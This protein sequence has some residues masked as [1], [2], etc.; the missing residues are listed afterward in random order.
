MGLFG[1]GR[2]PSKKIIRILL[3]I[4]SVASMASIGVE[5]AHAQPI[6]QLISEVVTLYRQS[7]AVRSVF[8]ESRAGQTLGR[9]FSGAPVA[10]EQDL[11]ALLNRLERSE[12]TV[13]RERLAMVDQEMAA[14]SR[15][16][17]SGWN[18]AEWSDAIEECTKRF[19]TFSIE[20]GSGQIVLG[21]LR[22]KRLRF[23]AVKSMEQELYDA[24]T[25]A[26][27]RFLERAGQESRWAATS[28][29]FL[30]LD[31]AARE[32]GFP[33][34]PRKAPTVDDILAIQRA[35]LREWKERLSIARGEYN[36]ARFI[37]RWTRRND[38]LVEI[39]NFLDATKGL[40]DAAVFGASRGAVG[41][42]RT[43]LLRILGLTLVKP[44][45]LLTPAEI[46][47][48][49][50]SPAAFRAY[51]AV[52]FAQ[53]L[54][55]NL[56]DVSGGLI[57]SLSHAWSRKPLIWNLRGAGAEGGP[58][59]TRMLAKFY[60]LTQS[61]V[62]PTIAFFL[63]I[64]GLRRGMG[65]L[66]NGVDAVMQ[67]PGLRSVLPA[68]EGGVNNPTYQIFETARRHF[69]KTGELY[70]PTA[71]QWEV[72]RKYQAVSGFEELQAFLAGHP[73][74]SQ[75]REYLHYAAGAAV[76]AGTIAAVNHALN[77]AQDGLISLEEYLNNPE[78]YGPGPGE[79]QLVVDLVPFPHSAVRVAFG[80]KIYSY[81]V[82]YFTARPLN[83]YLNARKIE[84]MAHLAGAPENA[85][86]NAAPGIT[87]QPA[88]RSSLAAAKDWVSDEAAALLGKV[89]EASGWGKQP[90]SVQIITLRLGD[91]DEEAVANVQRLKRDFEIQ[92]GTKYKN[93]TMVNDCATMIMRAVARHSDIDLAGFFSRTID[94][95][96][97]QLN[98]WFSMEKTL[99]EAMGRKSRVGKTF[100]VA[101]EEPEN[102]AYHLAR[103]T[104]INAFENRVFVSFFWFNQAWRAGIDLTHDESEL[105]YYTPE[106]QRFIESMK[107][108]VAAQVPKDGGVQTLWRI[109]RRLGSRDETSAQDVASEKLEARQ[110]IDETFQDWVYG[111]MGAQTRADTL[112]ADFMDIIRQGA[113]AE[114]L[115][116]EWDQILRTLYPR[117]IPQK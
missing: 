76:G 88:E 48:L 83:E 59:A 30:I 23:S 67:A 91:T 31:D 71:E 49:R 100:Q 106:M 27:R 13:L 103:N 68:I 86:P 39:R 14:W 115:K 8:A 112:E 79:I 19:L 72:L 89:Y 37:R 101:I 17:S 117:G 105:Q 22:P 111:P 26:E 29:E 4:A 12:L 81:G 114:A 102:P 5:Q 36:D 61:V 84:A 25:A 85:A 3:T 109:A 6:G 24:A 73:T 44:A 64:P 20:G 77:Q 53:N 78:K 28:Q 62:S 87:P 41:V 33:A 65:W 38:Y 51:R 108:E 16:R 113:R 116:R 52:S 9:E 96:P 45:H 47:L 94:A 15:G 11:Y 99:A 10:R 32:V 50:S 57:S 63:P 54:V 74:W 58:V 35:S 98:L 40:D 75:I 82:E 55:G 43:A 80:N 46:T 93:E 66:G 18:S 7:R 110:L 90:Q 92:V 1:L 60:R 21:A 97:S 104:W 42:D 70:A 2:S 56:W 34:L 107:Q 95:S 69:I